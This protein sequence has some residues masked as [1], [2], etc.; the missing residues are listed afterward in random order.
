MKKTKKMRN[1]KRKR[2][3]YKKKLNNKQYKQKI[4]IGAN[5]MKNHSNHG[6]KIYNLLLFHNYKMLLIN[7]FK[8]KK[9]S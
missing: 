5:K 1:N 7:K 8:Q 2:Q 9:K 4:I 6:L 3:K